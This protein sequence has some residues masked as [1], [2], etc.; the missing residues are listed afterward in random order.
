MH[1]KTQG[2]LFKIMKNFKWLQQRRLRPQK[3]VEGGTGLGGDA[4]GRSSARQGG[5]R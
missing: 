5:H 2:S 1:T 4:A 3:A